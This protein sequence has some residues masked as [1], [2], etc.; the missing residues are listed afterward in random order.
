M[1]TR[2]LT[3]RNAGTSPD[4]RDTASSNRA[5]SGYRDYLVA[6]SE[7]A[8]ERLVSRARSALRLY[9]SARLLAG[10]ALIEATVEVEQRSRAQSPR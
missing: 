1:T 7:G 10:L 9:D 8:Q 4:I 2:S 6:V 5:E 3:S